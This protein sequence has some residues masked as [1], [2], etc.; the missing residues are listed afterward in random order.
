MEEIMK[1]TED[2]QLKSKTDEREDMAGKSLYI[3][4]AKQSTRKVKTQ[5]LENWIH[6]FYGYHHRPRK[7]H[8]LLTY[9]MLNDDDNDQSA[10]T[11]ISIPRNTHIYIHK[12]HIDNCY[13]TDLNNIYKI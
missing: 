8:E 3:Y 10:T 13:V 9:H 2:T 11:T 4:M 1:I 5:R 6:S 12:M 7:K